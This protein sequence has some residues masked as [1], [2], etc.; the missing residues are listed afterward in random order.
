MTAEQSAILLAIR[1][2]EQLYEQA[3]DKHAWDIARACAE[4]IASKCRQ[5]DLISKEKEDG[6]I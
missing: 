1:G 6:T 2:E 4:S 3:K 5:L